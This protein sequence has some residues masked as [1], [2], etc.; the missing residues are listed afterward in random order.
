MPAPFKIVTLNNKH[1]IT[2]AIIIYNNIIINIFLLI[3]VNGWLIKNKMKDY[4]KYT[5]DKS[6]VGQLTDPNKKWEN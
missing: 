4:K 5:V 2:Y 3:T 6:Y 1:T